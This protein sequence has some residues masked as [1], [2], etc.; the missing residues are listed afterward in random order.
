M[1]TRESLWNYKALG[2]FWLHDST[3]LLYFQEQEIKQFVSESSNRIASY[4][5]QLTRLQSTLPYS[6]MTME[7]YAEAFPDKVIF[8]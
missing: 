5:D 2:D 7:D 1:N 8:C 6:Q 4:E 3:L